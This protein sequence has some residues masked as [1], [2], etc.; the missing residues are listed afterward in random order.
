MSLP[1]TGNTCIC[2]LK[3]CLILI[4][5][6]KN[7]I[8]EPV[9]L[10]WWMLHAMIL[11][12]WKKC[13]WRRTFKFS[14]E[15]RRHEGVILD[16]SQWGCSDSWGSPPHAW[17]ATVNWWL[18]QAAGHP[19]DPLGPRPAR[20]LHQYLRNNYFYSNLVKVTESVCH[21]DTYVQ[22]LTR[23]TEQLTS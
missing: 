4:Q 23:N 19:L 16:L 15:S 2:E 6:V 14:V 21:K 1:A 17:L 20:L 22:I 5:G 18:M 9:A 10:S 7:K 13:T 11:F 8:C 12:L 3:K